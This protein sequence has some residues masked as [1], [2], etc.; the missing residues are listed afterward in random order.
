MHIGNLVNTSIQNF[1]ALKTLKS[2]GFSDIHLHNICQATLVARLIY[3]SPSWWGFIK[4]EHQD[5]LEAVLRKASRCGLC[6]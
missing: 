3:G 1:Y 6:D 5:T 4:A 2:H